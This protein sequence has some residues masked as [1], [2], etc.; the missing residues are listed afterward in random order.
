[1]NHEISRSIELVFIDIDGCLT[2]DKGRADIDA[3]KDLKNLNRRSKE[4]R[5]YPKI[6]LV[7]GRPQPYVEAFVQL[8]EVQVPSI[9]ENGGIIYDPVKD[10]SFINPSISKEALDELR[11]LKTFFEENLPNLFPGAKMELGKEVSISLNP[12]KGVDISLFYEKVKKEVEDRARH[13]Y[14]TR[15]KSAVDILP[16]GIS[17]LSALIFVVKNMGLSLDK[18]CGI[19]DSINDIELLKNVG[20]PAVPANSEDEVKKIALYIS[21]YENGRGVVD[22]VRKCVELNKRG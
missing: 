20:F 6:T 12:P 17:K 16:A 7:S 14:I 8:L 19:G 22:I 3:I 1:M 21:P 15:S 13:L 4:S 2:I 18:V 9:C 5:L 11:K 10:I